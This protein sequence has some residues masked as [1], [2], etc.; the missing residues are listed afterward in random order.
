MPPVSMFW[1][2]VEEQGC[3]WGR[4]AGFLHRHMGLR[5]CEWNGSKRL[6]LHPFT[7]GYVTLSRHERRSPPRSFACLIPPASSLCSPMPLCR[8]AASFQPLWPVASAGE[9]E[10][11]N[12]A[13][14]HSDSSMQPP[15]MPVRPSAPHFHAPNGLRVDII[16]KI[17]MIR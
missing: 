12:Q 11:G 6:L 17:L 10:Q 9:G 8:I 5:Q 2:R 16:S 13:R 15:R 7:A 3:S 1:H 14:P 4:L